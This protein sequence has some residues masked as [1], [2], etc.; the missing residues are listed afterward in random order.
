M[1]LLRKIKNKIKGLAFNAA[2]KKINFEKLKTLNPDNFTAGEM[3][4]IMGIKIKMTKTLC[5]IAIRQGR[6]RKV[7]EDHYQLIRP[8]DNDFVG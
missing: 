2:L 4:E 8:F 3:A 6:F 7:D 5:E 1:N